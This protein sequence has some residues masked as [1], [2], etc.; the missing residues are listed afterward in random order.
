MPVENGWACAPRTKRP[1]VGQRPPTRA[2]APVGPSPHKRARGQVST[3]GARRRRR[4]GS[5]C[6]VAG[7]ALRTCETY[8]GPHRVQELNLRD[9]R[10]HTAACS[11]SSSPTCARRS[12]LLQWLVATRLVV[13]AARRHCSSC[14]SRA[15][16]SSRPQ[17]SPFSCLTEGC[18]AAATA[19]PQMQCPRRQCQPLPGRNRQ[20]NNDS[21]TV[22]LRGWHREGKKNHQNKTPKHQNTKTQIDL[23]AFFKQQKTTKRLRL[24]DRSVLA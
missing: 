7:T 10:K 20:P 4:E 3:A 6:G 1:P 17:T 19:Q 16:R 15:S 21:A 23:E 12:E 2:A 22:A 11:T 9:H 13:P 5:S 14:T 24:Q 8:C 18:V